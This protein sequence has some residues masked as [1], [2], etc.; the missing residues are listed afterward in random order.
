VF[1][2]PAD[3]APA[4]F[5]TVDE[6]GA[7]LVAVAFANYVGVGGTFEV[8]GFPDTGNGV[9]FRNSRVR[10]TEI[11]D[12]TSNTL[13]VG[14]RASN[15]SPMTTW[16]GGVTNS[17]NPPLNPGYDEEGPATL[18]LTNTGTAADG[19]VPNNALDHVEDSSSRHTQG[20]N[21]LLCDGSVRIIN[22]TINP[23]TWQALGTR[24]GGEVA[25]DY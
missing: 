1:L 16:V 18:V 4:A 24:A 17:V 6:S 10:L 12:G 23:A 19:R 15:R 2:C 8:T 22:N 3:S 21:F 14:E 25:G 5:T 11:T 9:L 20:V 13:C 7:P